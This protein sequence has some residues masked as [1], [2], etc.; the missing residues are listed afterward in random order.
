[1]TEPEQRSLLPREETGIA[2]NQDS[3]GVRSNIKRFLGS[4]Y[5]HYAV[6][7]LVGVDTIGIFATFLIELYLCEHGCNKVT[8][9]YATLYKVQHVLEIISLVFSCLFMLEL[10]ASVFAFGLRLDLTLYYLTM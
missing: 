9:K 8:D 3:F 2:S 1:M 7:F 5:G 6:L 10:S 4:S